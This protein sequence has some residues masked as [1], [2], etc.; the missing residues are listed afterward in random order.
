MDDFV[1]F[2]LNIINIFIFGLL[3]VHYNF[4]AEI[5]KKKYEELSEKIIDESLKDITLKKR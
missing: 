5:C 4:K 2:V 3:A 1:W